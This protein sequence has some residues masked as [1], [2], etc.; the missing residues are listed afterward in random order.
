MSFIDAFSTLEL[1]RLVRRFDA[2][3]YLFQQGQMGQTMF[4]VLEGRVDLVAE[5]NAQEFTLLSLGPGEFLGEKAL[6]RSGSYQRSYGAR[7]QIAST[8]VEIGLKDIESVR[9]LNP[10]GMVDILSRVFQLAITRLEKMNSL[11]RA[12]RS[13]DN[14]RRVRDLV[15]YFSQTQSTLLKDGRRPFRLSE[16]SIQYHIDMEP[17]QIREIIDLMLSNGTLV[18][19]D[20]DTFLVSNE[21]TLLND[22][23]YVAA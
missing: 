15:L 4:I 18:R 2:G 1:K 6:I 8:V 16:E 12:L 13:S 10:A 3:K 21:E 5:R 19:I 17:R 14:R 23:L 7:A 9:S 22:E 20:A 11:C